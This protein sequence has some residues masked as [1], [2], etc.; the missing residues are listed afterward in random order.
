[1]SHE[2]ESGFVVREQA[3][4]GLAT[5][6][7]DCPSIE[8]GI[9]MAGLD[10]AVVPSPIQVLTAQGIVD[11]G[12]FRAMVRST[13]GSILAVLTEQYT[14]LQNREAFGFFQGFLD[15]GLCA[16]ES[17]GSLR[18]G[19]N[20][21]VLAKV[22]GAEGE[23]SDGDKVEGY[24]LLSNAHD[25]SRAV[26]V[27][28]TP[29]RVVCWNTLS[30]SH[31]LADK[32]ADAG[33]G[34]AVRIH[35]GKDVKA[36]LK[37]VQEQV[38]VAARR[39]GDV[40]KLSKGLRRVQLDAGGFYKFM[41]QVYAPERDE[42]RRKLQT[43]YAVYNDVEKPKAERDVALEA[44]QKLEENLSK[45]FRRMSTVTVLANLFDRG[46]GAEMAGQTL[47]GAVNAVTHY[48]EHVKN[49]D[50][51]KRL[52]SS[53]FGGSVEKTRERAFQVAV[54]SL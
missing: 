7:Q 10:W 54:N 44:A 45:P 4:H 51:A 27:Q 41:E 2:F 20:V 5:V 43:L 28:F 30:T 31:G 52:T 53:W 11:G 40:L 25:G 22:Q 32:S 42:M 13:D 17:A 1:M 18:E 34:K 9:R 3:W 37:S 21:W 39:I 24:L 6:L 33:D 48:E 36:N 46:P 38:D 16:L 8:E 15:K 19:R 29:I 26:T 49:G 47:W 23:V 14:P 50:N 12:T 35:H